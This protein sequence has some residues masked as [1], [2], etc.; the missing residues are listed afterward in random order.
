MGR[1]EETV[2]GWA[3]Q[4][5]FL[6]LGSI[7]SFYLLLLWPA[8]KTLAC[9][10]EGDGSRPTRVGTWSCYW[11]G[12]PAVYLALQVIVFIAQD[13]KPLPI[14]EVLI[15]AILSHNQGSLIRTIAIKVLAPIYRKHYKTLNGLPNLV[16]SNIGKVPLAPVEWLMTMFLGGGNEK[17]RTPRKVH[18]H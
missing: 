18:T 16:R 17:Q 6:G 2:L 4:D 13:W 1:D 3:R 12:A 10:T 7:L 8:V 15:A 5:W 9:I 14:I 11:I